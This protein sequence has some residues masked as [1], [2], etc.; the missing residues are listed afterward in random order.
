[1]EPDTLVGLSDETYELLDKLGEG[2]FGAVYLARKNPLRKLVALK[3]LDH[4]VSEEAERRLWDEALLLASLQHP[5]IVAAEDLVQF[6]GQL[7]LVTE[8]VEGEDL[9]ACLGDGLPASALI[10]AIGQVAWALHAAAQRGVVHRDVKP[11][12]IR[13]GRHGNVKLLDFGIAFAEGTDSEAASAMVG[14]PRYMAP[15][16]FRFE[17]GPASDVFSLGC[18][19][20]LGLTG[21]HFYGERR[22]FEEIAPL[23]GSDEDWQGFLDAW[24]TTGIPELDELVRGMVARASE[25]R[26][27]AA[28]VGR[29]CE[30][31][32]DRL[33]RRTRLSDWCRARWPDGVEVPRPPTAERTASSLA[34]RHPPEPS[35]DDEVTDRFQP[36]V[37][38]APVPADR[39]APAA[40]PRLLAL[41][42]AAALLGL[43]GIGGVGIAAW[44]ASTPPATTTVVP[45][46]P[47][48]SPA[49]AIAPAPEPVPTPTKTCA[50]HHEETG[51]GAAP[52]PRARARSAPQA[53]RPEARR[54]PVRPGRGPHDDLRPA[55]GADPG[56]AAV[57]AHGERE[58]AADVL[59]PPV[60][61][62]R[63][64]LGRRARTAGRR[65]RG[66]CVRSG[67]GVDLR[68][69][70]P[71]PAGFADLAV[72]QYGLKR[73][74]GHPA[75]TDGLGPRFGHPAS[76]GELQSSA[77]ATL[78]SPVS[79]ELG[80]R[81]PCPHR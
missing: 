56:A 17:F 28:E 35:P 55:R 21:S 66:V 7:G 10:E 15:E 20:W 9:S 78:P 1:M 34:E 72:P 57:R 38:P 62:D 50:A 4:R 24:P 16:R 51:P 67:R 53:G 43:V 13:I 19:L 33:P 29:R 42:L 14:T 39:P 65:A 5:G 3:L 45:P 27:T 63:Q 52:R 48:P 30:E 80:V 47:A 11:Q 46:A 2:G 31:M 26:P 73:R 41:T 75:L 37:V 49:P 32:I 58:L 71:G 77:L 44:Y 74:F 68:A 18:I 25:A 40:A 79:S 6:R 59:G 70:R 69:D 36:P 61:R 54:R 23:T 64:R 76:T 8:Y 81:P 60:R 12:N 22:T